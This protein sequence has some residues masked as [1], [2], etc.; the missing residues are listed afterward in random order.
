MHPRAG[1]SVGAVAVC[2]YVRKID[3]NSTSPPMHHDVPDNDLVI[4][5]AKNNR[6]NQADPA[7]ISFNRANDERISEE[8]RLLMVALTRSALCDMAGRSASQAGS[9]IRKAKPI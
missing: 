4:Q 3:G 8:M 5:L 6:D 1:V 2:M 7:T 9:Q